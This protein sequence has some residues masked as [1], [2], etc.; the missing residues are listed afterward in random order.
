MPHDLLANLEALLA[1]GGDGAA[2][3]LALASRYLDAGDAAAAV[4]HA[5]AA[6]QLDPEYSAGVEGARPRVDGGGSRRGRARGLRAR[7][8]DSRTA[9]RPTG[10][11]GNARV[12]RASEAHCDQSRPA[13]PRGAQARSVMAVAGVV[14]GRG[15]RW[16]QIIRA[17]PRPETEVEQRERDQCDRQRRNPKR[18]FI[19]AC[20]VGCHQSRKDPCDRQADQ[21]AETA[22]GLAFQSAPQ[23]TTKTATPITQINI[24]R[25]LRCLPASSVRFL[26]APWARWVPRRSRAA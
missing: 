24:G 11:E 6:V 17:Q 26:R 19:H 7:H 1:K 10:R 21:R 22:F 13:E 18:Y 14:V 4:R 3:R 23:S 8:G 5:E 12:Q 16:R 15:R 25:A 9:R 20:H 2:L